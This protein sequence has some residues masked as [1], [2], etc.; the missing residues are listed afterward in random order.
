MTSEELSLARAASAVL[1]PGFAGTE[2]PEWLAAR[3]RGGLAGVCIFG[4]NIVSRV[5]LARLCADI[6]EANPDSLIAIDEEGGDVTRL[7]SDQGSPYP[8]NALL[9]RI[10]DLDYTAQ[11]ARAVGWELRSVGVNLNFAPD[12]DINSNPL[13]PVIG[14]RSFGAEP[15]L[16]ARH[17]AA[18]V[19]A[20]E[21]TGVAVS[22]KHFPGHGD[23]ALDSHLAVPVVDVSLSELRGREFRPFIAAI[24]AGARTVMTSHIV[25][26]Q[27]DPANPATL[28]RHI[29]EDVLRTELGF[30]GVIITDALDMKGASGQTGIPEA[31]V[32]AIAAGCDLLCIGTNNTDEELQH[33]EAALSDAIESGRMSAS[34]LQAAAKR[35]VSLAR[36]LATEAETL[37]LPPTGVPHPEFDL[38]RSAAAFDVAEP[39]TI[40]AARTLVAIETAANIAIGSSP[41]GTQV[42]ARVVEGESLPHPS[43]QW[44][45][46][47]KNNHQHA[48]VREIIDAARRDRPSTVVIDMGWPSDDRAYADVATFGASRHVGAA[49]QLWLHNAEIAGELQ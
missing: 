37:P 19:A 39:V 17:T 29:L 38:D 2:L 41:W 10:D 31:A 18:W 21:A 11:V 16:V 8:G 4:P 26:T 32:R 40:F 7:Y 25:L 20:H 42:D 48:W 43:G 5:Q 28:S 34:R 23:T 47:G 49:L 44:V 36:E 24:E 6:R 9:G 33:I 3:L 22:A 35:N 45:L 14:V 30:T 1:L 46:I 27:L 13:N 12:A 15:E